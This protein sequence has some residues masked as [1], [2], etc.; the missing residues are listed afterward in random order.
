VRLIWSIILIWL[1]SS[2]AAHAHTRSQSFSNWSIDGQQ[3]HFTFAVDARRVTQLGQISPD[4]LGL[5]DLLLRHV[6]ANL[7]ISQ[8]DQPCHIGP[9]ILAGSFTNI[10]RLSG[11]V[12]C[13]E[14]MAENSPRVRMTPFFEV[15][16]THI[17]LARIEGKDSVTDMV[18]REGKS[19]FDLKP[20]HT[21]Q[22]ITEFLSI[23][24]HHVLSGLDH[25]LFLLVLAL[26]A[27]T[28]RRAL[29]CVTGFTLGHTLSLG[30]VSLEYVLPNERLI[31]ALIGFTIAAM[32]LEAGAEFGLKRQRAM[33][34]LAGLAL[35]TVLVPL[36]GRSTLGLGLALAVYAL[37]SGQLTREA[38][39]KFLPIMTIA[40]GIIH[41]AGFAGGLQELSLSHTNILKP[42]IGF[43]LG[44]E[45]AQLMALAAVYMTI[46]LAHKKGWSY[47]PSAIAATLLVF[48]M[49]C[50]W[51]AVRLW[52]A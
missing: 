28:P 32:A 43:N 16:P 34:A 27:R 44:V 36:S 40:F 37:A 13:P 45:M 1:F 4:T 22:S 47:R 15:S 42:L 5:D 38:S 46:W 52:A 21:P 11:K 17:H 9:L 10:M 30:L 49:G 48:G 3:A 18:L 29:L 35:V 51:F 12:L 24:F 2:H 8:N 7:Q 25:M 39:H 23:G 50:F 41:G 19:A 6:E 31:E 26:V 33:F 20:A 14:N